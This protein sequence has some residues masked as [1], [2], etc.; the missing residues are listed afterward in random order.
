MQSGLFAAIW[1]LR[2]SDALMS[3]LEELLGQ[4]FHSAV[5]GGASARRPLAWGSSRSGSSASLSGADPSSDE[6]AVKGTASGSDASRSKAAPWKRSCTLRPRHRYALSE[7]QDLGD[8][9][10]RFRDAFF[11]SRGTMRGWLKDFL[12]QRFL[13]HDASCNDARMAYVRVKRA[14]RIAQG[15][16][17][18]LRNQRSKTHKPG[19]ASSLHVRVFEDAVVEIN[20]SAPS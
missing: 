2:P 18:K 12:V 6:I 9:A 3:G 7:Q 10:C 20:R 14:V 19:E 1:L 17:E 4:A 13:L 16:T 5:A 11:E 15:G 8:E